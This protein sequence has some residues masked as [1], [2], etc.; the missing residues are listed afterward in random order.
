MQPLPDPEQPCGLGHGLHPKG[1]RAKGQRG[2]GLFP[3]FPARRAQPG[4]MAGGGGGGSRGEGMERW[5]VA[6]ASR[7]M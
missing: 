4:L 6:A 1:K 3:R 5:E 2:Q 7:E